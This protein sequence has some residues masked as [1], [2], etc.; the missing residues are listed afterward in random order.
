MA[1]S[2][3]IGKNGEPV[4]AGGRRQ[5]L[6]SGLR[7]RGLYSIFI[8]SE[9]GYSLISLFFPVTVTSDFFLFSQVLGYARISEEQFSLSAH[10]HTA[11]LHMLTPPLFPPRFLLAETELC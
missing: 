3:H 10:A 8:L 11:S 7:H 6:T 1:G 2:Q 4:S 9:P 5:P